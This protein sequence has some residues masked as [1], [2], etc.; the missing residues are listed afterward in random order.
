[1]SALLRWLPWLGTLVLTILMGL[2][3]YWRQPIE[4]VLGVMGLLGVLI[5]AAVTMESQ[6]RNSQLDRQHQLRMA[7]LDKRLQVH[8]E[9]YALWRKLLANVY[10]SDTIGDIVMECQE[11]WDQNCLYLTSEA[12]VSFRKAYVRA[13]NH[14]RFVRSKQDVQLIEQ[15]WALIVDAGDKLVAGV[16]LPGLGTLE[17]EIDHAVDGEGKISGG[18]AKVLEI[19]RSKPLNW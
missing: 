13:L 7:A 17:S 1:M 3:V 4:L 8:Q 14:D 6:L 16:A 12:R 15:N 9:A 19:S 10:N 18:G 5:G 11:W 2:I